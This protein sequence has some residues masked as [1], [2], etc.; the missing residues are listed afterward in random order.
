MILALVGLAQA[1]D[2]PTLNA[3]LFSPSVDAQQTFWLEDAV[4]SEKGT[5]STGAL[6]QWLNAPFAMIDE[7]GERTVLEYI[8]D[9]FL[10]AGDTALRER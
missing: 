1:Q 8:L 9:P 6:L 3:Q 7:T 5:L 4:V 2:T 10:N